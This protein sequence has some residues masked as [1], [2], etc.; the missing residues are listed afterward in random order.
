MREWYNV[1]AVPV[2][3]CWALADLS[4]AGH[5]ITVRHKW[6]S[7]LLP[8]VTNGFLLRNPLS[9]QPGDSFILPSRV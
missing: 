4:L 9:E 5:D 7:T 8:T 2:G 1:I 6:I 3:Q